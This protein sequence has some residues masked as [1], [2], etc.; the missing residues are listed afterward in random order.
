MVNE[1]IAAAMIYAQD[2]MLSDN[3]RHK[4]CPR[5]KAGPK[6][7]CFKCREVELKPWSKEIINNLLG[8]KIIRVY[9]HTHTHT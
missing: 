9:A 2:C 8:E 5:Y 7:V 6:K 3:Y 4:N 1:L